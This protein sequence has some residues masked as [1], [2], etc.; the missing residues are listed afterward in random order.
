MPEKSMYLVLKSTF[1]SGQRLN[2]GDVVELSAADARALLASGR[3]VAAPEKPKTAPAPADRSVDLSASD[4]PTL[5]K[6]AKVKRN[7]D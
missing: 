4:T 7:A 1:A 5:S 3:V 2:A 6:R